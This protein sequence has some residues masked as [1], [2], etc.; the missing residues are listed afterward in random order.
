MNN[1]NLENYPTKNKRENNKEENNVEFV[2]SDVID[3]INSSKIGIKV[4]EEQVIEA[5]NVLMDEDDD[6]KKAA[7]KLKEI[8]SFLEPGDD[9]NEALGVFDE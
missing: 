9:F 8:I 5:L 2:V 4:V 3:Y 6:A 7:D 1:F